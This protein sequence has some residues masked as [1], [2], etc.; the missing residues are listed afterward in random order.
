M[1]FSFTLLKKLTAIFFL[2]F[3]FSINAQTLFINE[4]M[5][6]NS[7]TIADPDFNNY[8]DWIEIYN[9]GSASVNLKNYYITDNLSQ[10]QKFQIQNDFIVEAGGYVLIWADDANT[11]NHANFKL[12]ADGESIGLFDPAV[13]LID[14]L[15]YGLQQTDISFGRFPNGTNA[16]FKFSPATPASAN[17]E[18]GIFNILPIPTISQ[19]SGFYQTSI[20][21]SAAHTLTDVTIR[22]TN[23]GSIPTSSS[24]VYSIPLQIDST[25]VLRFR[26]FK[27]GFTPS[28]AETRTYFINVTTDLPVFSLVTDPAN[29]FS[30]TSGIYVAG[31]NGIIGNC[32]TEPRN[33][34]QD[35]ERPVTLEFF[36]ADKSLAFHVNAGVKIYGGCSRL[37]PEKSLAFYFRGEYGNDKLRYRLFDDI[38][39]YE[40]NNFT[41]RSSG[42]DWWR[43]MFRDGMAQ[44]LI[45]QGMKLDYQNYRPSILFINGN[46]WGI[47]N[48]REKLNEHYLFYH[49]GIDKDNIDLVE[50]GKGVAGNNGDLIA[51]NE[52]IDFLTT[53]NM[54]NPLNYDYIKSIVDI[55]EYI[56][57]QVAEIYSANGDWPGSNMKL[58]RERKAGSKWRW[59]VYDLDFT[60]GGNAQGLATT[61]TL[62]QATATNG[63]SWPNPPW[64][65]LMLRKLLDNTDFKNEFIQRM[66]AHI[67]TTYEPNHVLFVIDSLANNI[68]A[69]IPRHKDRW[70]QSI[71]FG[72]TWQEL[73]DMMRTFA[74]DRPVNIR[75]HFNT[76]FSING[77]AS[78][79]ISRN[80]PAWGK[81][82][83]AGVEVKNNTSTNIFFKNIPIR[84]KA[85]PMPGYR[86]VQWQGVSTATSPEITVVLDNNSTLT[87][88]F[89][90]AELT[91]T[92]I[93]I[94]E[95]NY[96]SSPVFDTEDWI[97]FYNPD[98]AAVNISGWKF[99]D[100]DIANQFVFPNGTTIGAQDYLVLCR[101]TLKFKLL[102]PN[103]TKALGNINFGLSSSGD[104]IILKDNSDNLVDEV[105]YSS[106]GNWTSLPNGNGPTLALINPQLDNSLAENWRASGLYG[107][108]GYLNDIYTKVEDEKILI[109]N[110]FVLYQNYP[111]PFNPSTKISWQSPVGGWQTLKVYDVLGNEVVTLVDE[112]RN[113]GSYEIEFNA[114]LLSSGVYFYK[115]QAG[116]FVE[117][118]KMILVK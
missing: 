24:N 94:N 75:G 93:V 27:D 106:S 87:A 72:N 76:K 22:F 6:S 107:T 54:S 108:P 1:R 45:E 98:S 53:Q 3:S 78:I 20:N 91:I 88:V 30:D 59:M 49:H 68:A 92:S 86:F 48:I 4:F 71:S 7:T 47:H 109:P 40:Y 82:F 21:V 62:A 58:W 74:V 85:M 118:R 2:L 83:T 66:A 10:P 26:A 112:F 70:P 89:E 34:N 77:S 35:W 17:L 8:A 110:E 55:D 96:K 50:I 12:S 73:I 44:T 64:S 61:N 56:D 101:D 33:W 90:P 57:Y 19:Q 39:V 100:D 52:M 116:D 105:I 95:I 16:W 79:L 63:P 60:F 14:T 103:Q 99:T 42:Q 32:S 67:N 114:S 65:T 37:Y 13:Q 111:N 5:A 9:A 102:Y 84:I 25:S 115:L 69:E 43:T 15:T 36:E 41:L 113:A 81:I 31:T 46:Y 80:N 11:G 38:P 97:E 18:S 104:H 28:T 23:D 51:Y 117:T 29:F